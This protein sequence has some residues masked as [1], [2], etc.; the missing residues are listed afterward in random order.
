MDFDTESS[1]STR[2]APSSEVKQMSSSLTVT[3][4]GAIKSRVVVQSTTLVD[5]IGTESRGPTL[6]L[7]NRAR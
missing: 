5:M 4:S 2:V 1:A 6:T 7:V 3:E